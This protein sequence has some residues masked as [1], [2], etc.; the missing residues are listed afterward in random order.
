MRCVL[1]AALVLALVAAGCDN[2][3]GG[4]TTTAPTAAAATTTETFTGTLAPQGLNSHNFTIAVAGQVAITLT[5]VGPPATITVGLGV[6]VPSGT[7]CSLTLGAGSVVSAQASSTPQIAGT[8]A[9]GALCVA[10]Y[11]L[12]FASNAG[13]L[14]NPVDYSITVAHS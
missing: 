7:T 13:N 9:A 2:S 10:I 3:A 14:A 1:P 4:G 12:A 8:S 11:D 5:A 6:G